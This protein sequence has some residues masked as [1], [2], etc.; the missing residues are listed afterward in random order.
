MGLAFGALS[1]ALSRLGMIDRVFNSHLIKPAETQSSN[2]Q[3]AGSSERTSQ[4]IDQER[5]LASRVCQGL[6]AWSFAYGF[7]RY[8]SVRQ[9]LLRG[10]FVP[11]LWGPALMTGGSIGSLFIMLQKDFE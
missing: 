4:S 5:V 3:E 2:K 8:M 1:L 10:S 9:K 11:A 6:S 7:F